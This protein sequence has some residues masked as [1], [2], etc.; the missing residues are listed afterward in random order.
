MTIM[1]KKSDFLAIPSEEYKG[2]L[3]LRY[4]VF[5]QRLEWDLV[6][7][8]NLESDEYDNSN[9]EYIYACDD[10]ENVSGCWRLLPTTG[11]Y[12]LK[13]VFPELLGQQSAPKDPNIVELSRFAVGK[14]S[15]KINNSASEITMKLF[16]AIYKHAVSQGITEYVTVTSTAIERF[17]KRIKVPC[18]RIGDK[19]I[20]VL[21]DT[22]SVV[23]S[24]PINEQFKKAVLN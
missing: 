8:N 2:I 13:S 6:V 15:S 5:K 14:N 22:K 11:D 19:E 10:T 24:M 23:L 21:G 20:H 17:L 9:A 18:H 1:I 3:S 12:M 4:Q 7:E 16:E